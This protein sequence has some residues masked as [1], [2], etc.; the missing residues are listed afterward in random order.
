[1]SNLKS[2]ISQSFL[3]H[4]RAHIMTTFDKFTDI[5]ETYYEKYKQAHAEMKATGA[6]YAVFEHGGRW[7]E[8]TRNCCKPKRICGARKKTGERC[9]SKDLHRGGKCKFHGGLS[10]GARTPGG[11]ARAIAAMQRGKAKWLSEQ[12]AQA[13]GRVKTA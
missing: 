12:Y 4:P 9:R 11:K 10:T 7:Y 3:S 5:V 2:E 13:R 8:L 6:A 1:M